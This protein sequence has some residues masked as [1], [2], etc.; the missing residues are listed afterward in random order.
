MKAFCSTFAELTAIAAGFSSTRG[1]L[2]RYAKTRLG[3]GVQL[4]QPHA[5]HLVQQYSIIFCEKRR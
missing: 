4:G 1:I 5:L 3:R 2:T